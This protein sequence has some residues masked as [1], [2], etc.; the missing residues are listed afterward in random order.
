MKLHSLLKSWIKRFVRRLI[1]SPADIFQF[2]AT[3]IERAAL[4]RESQSDMARLFFERKGRPAHKW[5]HYL[6]IYER[7]FAPFR[8]KPVRML[9]IG[10]SY[11]GSLELWRSYFGA[12]ATIFGVDIEPKCASRVDAP[13]QVRIGSQRDPDFL[14]SVVAEMGRP[15][16]ILDDGS[17]VA[18]HQLASFRTLFP[19]LRTGGL[20]VI[21]DA[22]SAYW[23]ESGGGYGRRDTAIGLAF[24]IIHDMHAWYHGKATR[25][26]AK[27]EI[28]GIHVY[29]SMIVIEKGNKSPPRHMY[30]GCDPNI[31]S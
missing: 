16:I 31:Q 28:D 29:D 5:V 4:A 27:T 24:Q 23:A 22:H 26:T 6:D 8:Q 12:E 19:L 20:Y 13:N 9:E 17:H 14:A 2:Q 1:R 21:E 11:G 18:C 3:Q 25:T 7:H 15:D 30:S 10:V